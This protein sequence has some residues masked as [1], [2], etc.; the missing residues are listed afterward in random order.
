MCKDSEKDRSFIY[1]E[2][3]L[4]SNLKPEICITSNTSSFKRELK[5]NKEQKEYSKYLLVSV[6]KDK[7]GVGIQ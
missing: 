2:P 3:I 1:R 6:L 7:Y 4:W 5:D